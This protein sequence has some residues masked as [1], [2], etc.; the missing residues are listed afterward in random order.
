VQHAYAAGVRYFDTAPHYG[1]GLSEIRIGKAF[2][3]IARDEVVLS[4]KVGR[5][6]MPDPAAPSE[7]NGYVDV[8][9]YRQRWDYSRQGTLHSI[10]DSLQRLGVSRLDL[11]Y[12]HDIDRDTHGAGYAQRLDEVLRGAIPALADLRERGSIGGYGLG[13]ND[14]RV[15]VEVLARTDLDVILLA[16]RY[17][18]LDQ[19]AL[20]E[21]LPLCQ[22]R[23][24]ALVSGGP[25]NSGI[26]A[27][28]AKPA[29]GTAM[30]RPHA[31]WS[32]AS[33]RS[34]LSVQPSMSRCA[35]PRCSFRARIRPSSASSPVRV[36]LPNSTRISN[37]RHGPCR[38]RSGRRSS[39]SV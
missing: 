10:E 18:L 21:L 9:P 37:S 34:S 11:V 5:I 27:T 2:R 24:V 31:S 28:G 14:W 35:P 32:R 15:C 7:Q 36:R 38:H 6:L 39:I 13:V 1:N 23:G 25:Y 17:T 8:P 20:P 30:R 4:S 22:R 26:L 16:G 29:D 33:P 12:I 19:T 3:G